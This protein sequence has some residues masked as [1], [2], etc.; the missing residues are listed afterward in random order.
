MM[1]EFQ[2]DILYQYDPNPEVL[3]K[4]QNAGFN[5]IRVPSKVRHPLKHICSVYKIFKKNHYEIVH[6]HLDYF[7]NSYVCFLAI[8]AG[9]KK[10]IAHHHQAYGLARK[11]TFWMP[12]CNITCTFMR[13]LCKSFATDWVACGKTA[14]IN[15]WGKNAVKE[16]KVTVLPN[17][18]DPEQF[19]YNE[20]ERQK[21][22]KEN[23]IAK[24]DYVV[25]HVGR[26][27]P[28]KNHFFLIDVFFE[29]HKQISNT[30]LLLL[31]DGPLQEQAKQKVRELGL[32]D[33]VVFAG[34]RNNPA[35]FYSAMDVFCLPSL[36]EGLPMTL[37]E[38]QYNGLPCIISD[39]IT[40]EANV[41]KNVVNLPLENDLWLDKIQYARRNNV[42]THCR[43]SL[44]SINEQVY[45][46]KK[47]YLAKL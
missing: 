6:S 12:F 9:V 29:L 40:N 25:G 2:F 39:S 28:Q 11:E 18:I 21:I 42:R 27:Y 44:Y 47:I 34:I 33:C 35:S 16:G 20:L 1:D 23:G 19:K 46:L 7:M 22:R 38:A 8:L 31:G 10:R 30:K 3:S 45:I 5:C 14:A 37:I 15:G 26:F 24:D 36:W 4:F 17:A 41:S 43:S 13:F 32:N